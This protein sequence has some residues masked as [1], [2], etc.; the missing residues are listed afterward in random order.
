MIKIFRYISAG[1]L[2]AIFCSCSSTQVKTLTFKPSKDFVK[3]SEGMSDHEENVIGRAVS[4]RIF[5]QY[6]A[7]SSDD[8]TRYLNEVGRTVVASSPRPETFSGYSFVILETDEINAMS[9]PGGYI[10]LSR[11][12]LRLIP[13]EDTLAAV[14]AH[15]VMHI[16]NRHG[17]KSI[18]PGHSANYLEVGQNVASAVDC[19]GLSQQL[20]L[21]FQ[22]AVNDVYDALLK[23]GYS[24]GQEFEADAGAVLILKKAGY[25][26]EALNTALK[27]LEKQN[28]KGGWFR[29]HPKPSDRL[30]AAAGKMPSSDSSVDAFTLRKL[31]FIK[32][33]NH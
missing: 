12:F 4:A 32:V 16:A 27:I 25:D 10:F 29:T 13:D 14:L 19:T 6:K 21:A 9:A 2:V 18:K 23:S 30:G 11:G 15:E 28:S 1:F 3:D 5:S 17:L 33:V 22:G 24:Q 7:A 20:L 26:P 31:R 8:L